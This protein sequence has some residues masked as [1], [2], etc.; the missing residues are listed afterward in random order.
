MMNSKFTDEQIKAYAAQFREGDA[1]WSSGKWCEVVVN[2]NL[3]RLST[4]KD[5][6]GNQFIVNR[7]EGY[8]FKGAISGFK[9]FSLVPV[10]GRY[11]VT[12][13][14]DYKLQG[15]EKI[16]WLGESDSF[17]TFGRAYENKITES[18]I[19]YQDK[20]GELRLI[21]G[22]LWGIIPRYE[23]VKNDIK[24]LGGQLNETCA[25]KSIKLSKALSNSVTNRPASSHYHTNNN[26]NDVCQFAD[27]NL[28]D[29]RVKGFHQINAIKYVSRY[30]KK[31][32]SKEKRIEDLKKAKVSIDKLIELEGME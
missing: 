8:E 26:G 12:T 1:I 15:G 2:D 23:Q 18:N 6:S 20:E 21:T 28:P 19:T 29:E 32:D 13:L 7:V 27:D 30:N 22:Y 4:K 14:D 25:S 24:I 31:H 11:R 9:E 5:C 3:E 16:V 10:R 17:R